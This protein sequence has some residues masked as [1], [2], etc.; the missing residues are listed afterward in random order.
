MKE[1]LLAR[2][3][4]I[5]EQRKVFCDVIAEM[6]LSYGEENAM[7]IEIIKCDAKITEIN[8]AIEYIETL[9]TK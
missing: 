5:T 6:G 7:R 9:K 8:K 4:K 3:E 1:Y 2:I